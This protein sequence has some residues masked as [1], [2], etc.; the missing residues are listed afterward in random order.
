MASPEAII[1]TAK[2]A[3]EVGFDSVWVSDHVVVPPT[4][5]Y[6]YGSSF[7]D[8]FICLSYAA[9]ETQRVKL[10]TT[11]VVV[12]LRNPFVQAKMLSTLDVLSGGRIIFGVGVGWD[13]EEFE[14]LGIPFHGR[15]KL[16]DEYLEIMKMLWT[17]ENPSFQGHHHS[18]SEIS[19]E[20]KPL[21]R[22]YI[23]IWVGGNGAQ[24]FRRAV[25]IGAAWHPSDLP[26]GDLG[27]G[28]ENMRRFA[29]QRGMPVPALTYR[30]YLRPKDINPQPMGTRQTAFEGSREELISYIG[31]YAR[32]PIEHLVIEF[33][34][35]NA[36]DLKEAIRYFAQEV[37][38]DLRR[39]SSN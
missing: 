32:L 1:G 17:S 8:P 27:D 13:Q 20:P 11:V 36:T 15:G 10:G 35:S 18:F 12:P 21:Q 7:M 24:A 39:R 33:V 29:S 31:Q 14:A 30:M 5:G 9:A 26:P 38:P 23:P 3:E 16:T 22:P 4:F 25:R 2:L 34:V 28:Y 19:F 6:T 37:L